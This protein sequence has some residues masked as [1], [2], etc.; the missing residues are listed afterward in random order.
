ML[1]RKLASA[2]GLSVILAGAPAAE[3]LTLA[4]NRGFDFVCTTAAAPGGA[5]VSSFAAVN[6]RVVPP[7]FVGQIVLPAVVATSP[8]RRFQAAP[9]ETAIAHD[10]TAA[11]APP[12]VF[13]VFFVPTDAFG[14][15]NGSITVIDA[16]GP[17][18]VVTALGLP[19]P[20]VYDVLLDPAQQ[21]AY[22][23]YVGP[24]G[25]LEVWALSYA[26]AP[27]LVG[28][29]LI[30]SGPP[31]PFATRLSINPSGSRIYAPQ[32]NGIGVINGVGMPTLLRTVVLPPGSNSTFVATN[33]DS[34]F[35]FNGNHTSPWNICGTDA[36]T[37]ATTGANVL[38]FSAS[39]TTVLTLGPGGFG[40]GPS[41]M[42]FN[43]A[44]G[45]NDLATISG[46]LGQ[47]NPSHVL[48]RDP[49]S[50]T[51]QGAV[52][53]IDSVPAGAGLGLTLFPMAGEPFGNPNMV[54][55]PNEIAFHWFDAVGDHVAVLPRVA[56]VAPSSTLLQGFVNPSAHDMPVIAQGGGA[57]SV[58]TEFLRVAVGLETYGI[59][60][61]PPVL[62]GNVPTAALS[63]SLSG[64]WRGPLVFPL[65]A[66]A[67][68]DTTTLVQ[69]PLG[70]AYPYAQFVAGGTGGRTNFPVGAFP[71]VPMPPSP[72]APVALPAIL[73]PK[74][75]AF[76]QSANT[77]V[78]T[79][80]NVAFDGGVGGI[81]GSAMAILAYG[82]VM[83]VVPIPPLAGLA[84]LVLS[85]EILPL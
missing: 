10:P 40:A 70:T 34:N 33:V 83:T 44:S 36:A 30:L 47:T 69:G 81:P 84:G 4:G 38:V 66:V 31:S 9:L 21:R 16:R 76:N 24:T 54:L 77:G 72:P 74:R 56:P 53:R 64:A 51:A 60:A 85:T 23:A 58:H 46:W 6:T 5:L 11:Y 80:T 1:M 39:G 15:N 48:L 12:A 63:I 49:A 65:T 22:C 7:A 67:T 17:A 28:G 71:F 52:G 43:L 61:P 73:G 57:A 55:A 75:P 13:G 14:G 35:P 3:D 18:P 62:A 2:F 19:S 8:N 20:C 78:I 37:S 45:I 42:Q 32:M 41:G 82:G 27:A 59:A 79:S 68:G 29:P 26:G 25:M 50:L